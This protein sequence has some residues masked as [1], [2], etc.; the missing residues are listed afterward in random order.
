MDEKNEC[1]QDRERSGSFLENLL[2]VQFLVT[3]EQELTASTG[4]QKNT[5]GIVWCLLFVLLFWMKWATQVDT[6]HKNQHFC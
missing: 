5:R 3:T 2:N 6:Q 1:Q 4:Q